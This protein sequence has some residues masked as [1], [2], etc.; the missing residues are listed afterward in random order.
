MNNKP[1]LITSICLCLYNDFDCSFSLVPPP[2]IFLVV[3]VLCRCLRRGCVTHSK[4]GI[5]EREK[6]GPTLLEC[7]IIKFIICAN[8]AVVACAEREGDRDF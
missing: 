4:K 7:G 2:L 6:V 1:Q 8:V 3:R 5:G